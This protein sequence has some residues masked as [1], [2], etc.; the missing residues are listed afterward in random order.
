MPAHQLTE[1]AI[2]FCRER[3]FGALSDLTHQERAW[4]DAPANGPMDYETFID[5]GPNREA[6]LEEVRELAAYGVL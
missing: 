1:E 6:L 3:S 2:V 4:R 5:D